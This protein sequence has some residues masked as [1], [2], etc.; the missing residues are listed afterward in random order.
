MKKAVRQHRHEAQRRQ[1]RI[2]SAVFAVIVIGVLG[3]TA[4]L[5]KQAFFRSVPPP[6]AG[7]VINVEASMRSFDPKERPVKAGEPVNFA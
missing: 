6:L 4:N 2:R 7:N 3:L 1:N 5:L